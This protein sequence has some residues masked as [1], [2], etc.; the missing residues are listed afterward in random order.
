MSRK[1][2]K[3]KRGNRYSRDEEDGKREK[4]LRE[5]KGKTERNGLSIKN[6]LT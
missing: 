6:L 4:N 2:G 5:I 1:R 3:K